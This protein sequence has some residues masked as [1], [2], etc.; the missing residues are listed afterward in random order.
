MS[1]ILNYLT[2][3]KQRTRIDDRVSEWNNVN[4]GVPQGSILGPLLF[5]IFING[6][7]FILINSEITNYADDNT[8]YV[9][10]TNEIDTI[11]GLQED[12]LKLIRWF[13]TNLLKMNSSKSHVLLTSDN[14]NL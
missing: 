13:D 4:I 14:G 6:L 1:L 11:N 8:P 5:K 7:F 10:K 12:A 3:R 9:C 2:N